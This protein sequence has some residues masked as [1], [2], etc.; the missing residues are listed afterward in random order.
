LA[1]LQEKAMIEEKVMIEEKAMIK[2]IEY[3][4]KEFLI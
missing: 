1:F 2:R 4:L 3:L